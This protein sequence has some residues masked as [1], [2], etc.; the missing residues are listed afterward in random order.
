MS[1]RPNT[2][3]DG[4]VLTGY[5]ATF[6]SS[7][8]PHGTRERRLNLAESDSPSIVALL[9]AVCSLAYCCSVLPAIS[10][11]YFRRH[12]RRRSRHPHHAQALKCHPLMRRAWAFDDQPLSCPPHRDMVR[13]FPLHL[14]QALHTVLLQQPRFASFF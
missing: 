2:A 4:L 12:L 9:V 8:E 14:H 5:F 6:A 13:L 1:A 3:V 11:A 10:P 7:Q